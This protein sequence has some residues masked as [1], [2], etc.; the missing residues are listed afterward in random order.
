MNA[1]AVPTTRIACFCSGFKN[2][3]MIAGTSM[4][5]QI[6]LSQGMPVGRSYRCIVILKWHIGLQIEHD[7]ITVHL[8]TLLIYSTSSALV[9]TFASAVA[10]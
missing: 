1:N 6:R 2:I 3:M 7:L 4:L 10:A 8:F 9:N 5:S